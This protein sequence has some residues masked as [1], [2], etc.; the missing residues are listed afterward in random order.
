MWWRRA[1]RRRLWARNGYANDAVEAPIF[2]LACLEDQREL[3]LVRTVAIIEDRDTEGVNA[4]FEAST[5]IDEDS[6]CEHRDMR[7]RSR[8]TLRSRRL[9]SMT[10]GPGE[11]KRQVQW[12]GE[13]ENRVG[14][15]LVA[16]KV[17]LEL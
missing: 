14:V 8:S 17:E 10:S 3:S 11:G 2:R 12:Q 16:F 15:Q 1:G 6:H 13:G 5:A 7:S 4:C 9:S